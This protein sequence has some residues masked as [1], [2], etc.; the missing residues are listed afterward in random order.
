MQKLGEPRPLIVTILGRKVSLPKILWAP[1][2]PLPRVG[3]FFK[4]GDYCHRVEK[5]IHDPLGLK[6]HG[7]VTLMLG[8]RD[9]VD[10]KV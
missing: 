8:D 4:I 6:D 9:Y 10:C 1:T 2:D 5:V 7:A 3:E